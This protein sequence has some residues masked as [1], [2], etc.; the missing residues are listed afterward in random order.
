MFVGWSHEDYGLMLVGRP[1][2]VKA[3]VRNRFGDSGLQ[4]RSWTCGS[5]LYRV[6]SSYYDLSFMKTPKRMGAREGGGLVDKID[7]S[8]LNLTVVH[9]R[10]PT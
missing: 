9:A 10:C 4:W 1:A 5:V 3:K 8:L 6:S 7:Q 2:N